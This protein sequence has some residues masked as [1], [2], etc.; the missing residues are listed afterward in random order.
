[1]IIPFTYTRVRRHGETFF[2]SHMVWIRPFEAH[3]RA[4]SKP[5]RDIRRNSL[6]P[7][8]AI[9][10]GLWRLYVYTHTFTPH[11]AGDRAVVSGEAPPEGCR[12]CHAVQDRVQLVLGNE[13]GDEPMPDLRLVPAHAFRARKAGRDR[14]AR[15]TR[16]CWPA[17]YSA[18]PCSEARN[19]ALWSRL[20]GDGGLRKPAWIA[21]V[22][23][24]SRVNQSRPARSS[25]CS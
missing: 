6:R 21:V 7:I 13:L 15:I 12:A 8:M 4:G 25:I 17:H 10:K 18:S 24:R 2:A 19:H 20:S 14:A 9:S 23:L 16:L 5:V 22:F 11:H 3:R 1:L